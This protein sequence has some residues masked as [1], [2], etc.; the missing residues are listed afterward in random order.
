MFVPFPLGRPF[1]EA[2]DAGFQTRVMKAALELLRRNDGPVLLEDFPDDAPSMTD[3][4]GWTPALALPVRPAGLPTVVAGWIAALEAEFGAVG[5]HWQ[6]AQ[7]RFGR[8]TVGNSRQ[9]MSAWAP[10]A[11]QFLSGGV[12]ENSPVEGL[13][14]AVVM[15]YI[16]D[17]IKAMYFE[18]V[19]AEGAQPSPLQVSRW[20]WGETLAGDFLRA[21]RSA[22]LD[23]EHN[24]FKTAGSR[25]IVPMPY[26]NTS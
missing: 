17:D 9:E 26:V 24:G 13:S 23:S 12:P 25:F 5:P 16:A 14:P 11:A 1:G 3:T 20:F 22:A 18:A 6:A 19:Q 2:E 8:T 21:L 4:A 15:R 10:F 7:E